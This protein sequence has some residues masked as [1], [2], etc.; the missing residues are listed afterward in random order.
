VLDFT[1]SPWGRGLIIFYS[2]LLLTNV[3]GRFGSDSE[4]FAS[5]PKRNLRFSN[6]RVAEPLIKAKAEA[7]AEL[8][9]DT[10]LGRK[11]GRKPVTESLF[12]IFFLFYK[13]YIST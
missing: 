13:F 9:G 11:F 6:A 8:I 7:R 3:L 10:C 2:S 5:S 1:L 4:G 12:V